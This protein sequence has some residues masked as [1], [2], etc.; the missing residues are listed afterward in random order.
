MK[1]HH[2]RLTFEVKIAPWRIDDPSLPENHDWCLW[3]FDRN[4]GTWLPL[5]DCKRPG[6]SNKIIKVEIVDDEASGSTPEDSN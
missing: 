4:L 2:L 3:V 1:P 6:E 5:N